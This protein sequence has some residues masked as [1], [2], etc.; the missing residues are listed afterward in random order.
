MRWFIATI[1]GCGLLG[2]TTNIR[3]AEMDPFALG[4]VW[5]G[6]FKVAVKDAEVQVWALTITERNGKAFKGDILVRANGKDVE[7]IAVSGNAT[8][9]NVG[10]IVFQSERMGLRQL[11]LTGKLLNGEAA[12]VFTGTN[13]FGKPGG[14]VATLKPKN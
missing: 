6:E 13:K 11:K 14:G 3:A 1:V 8:D 7:T 10:P 12:L 5:S 9:K 4:S 2:P